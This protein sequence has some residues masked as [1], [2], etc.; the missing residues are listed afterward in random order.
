[1]PFQIKSALFYTSLITQSICYGQPLRRLDILH[2]T[3]SEIA[4]LWLTVVWPHPLGHLES[5]AQVK[6]ALMSR[7]LLP[8][9]ITSCLGTSCLG[10]SCLMVEIIDILVFADVGLMSVRF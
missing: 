3:S 10:F 4:L 8:S 1:M 7:D 2:P 6:K 5:P 9:F